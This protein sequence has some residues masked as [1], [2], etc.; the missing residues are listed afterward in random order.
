L[1]SCFE[2]LYFSTS[3]YPNRE[4]IVIDNASTEEGTIDY[5]N[6]LDQRG[7]RVFQA[8]E[9][10]PSNEFARALNLTCREAKGD[11]VC[12]LQ[13]DMQ[14]ITTGWL[15]EYVKFYESNLDRLGCL[16]FDAQRKI[17]NFSHSMK[18]SSPVGLSDFKFVFNHE[19]PPIAGA[20]DVMYSRQVL[21]KIYPWSE[22][23]VSHEGGSDSETAMLQKVKNILET[24][25]KKMYCGMPLIP[26][27]AAIYTDMRGTQARV[28]GNKRYGRYVPPGRDFLY[29]EIVSLDSLAESL[30][31]SVF[32]LGIEDVANP[33]GWSKT[34][35]LDF[36][37]NWKKNPIRP[38]EAA[39]E[40]VFILGPSIDLYQPISEDPSHVS[41]WLGE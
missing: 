22:N 21:S 23:N 5:L 3:D 30:G 35:I 2:S 20:G 28:R 10:D 11:Y 1:K 26:V 39:S 17:T 4:F 27:A 37:G 25:K 40:D 7:V 29:Y 12:P 9:R 16:L 36:E 38:E 31:E 32:P 18:M 34:E 6:D 15:G 24:S 14:F 8:D 13:G 41:D 19:R 33:V